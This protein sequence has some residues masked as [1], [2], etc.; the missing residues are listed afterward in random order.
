MID[1]ETFYGEKSNRVRK[2]SVGMQ[3]GSLSE[4]VSRDPQ[5]GK[6]QDI[7]LSGKEN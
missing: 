6:E 7:G 5:E 2:G 1:G 4:R 3:E